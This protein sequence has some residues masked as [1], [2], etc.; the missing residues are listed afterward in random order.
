MAFKLLES[1]QQRR[2]AL[3]AAHLVTLVRAGAKFH[4]GAMIE[5]PNQQDQEAVA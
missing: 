5:R 4:K 2:R 3:N 1:A